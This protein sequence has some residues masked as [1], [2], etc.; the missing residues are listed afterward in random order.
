MV[1]EDQEVSL[2]PKENKVFKVQLEPEVPEDTLVLK[3]IREIRVL[4]VQLVLEV[5]E[6]SLELKENKVFKV[7]LDQ[8]DQEDSLELQEK[9]VL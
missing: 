1:P 9:M 3:V 7:K 6:V 8:W 5:Q 4:L 2:E